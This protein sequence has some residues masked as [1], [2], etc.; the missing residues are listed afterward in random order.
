MIKS[1][2]KLGINIRRIREKKGLLQ[3]DLC[4]KLSLDPAYMSKVESGQKNLTLAT[5]ERLAK[6]L[7]VP[8]EELIK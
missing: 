4:K 8:I 5:M 2:Q 6:A 3:S 1:A 7:E